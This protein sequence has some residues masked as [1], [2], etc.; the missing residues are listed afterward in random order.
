[1]P[2][3]TIEANTRIEHQ[4]GDGERDELGLLEVLLGLHGAVLG[5]RAV[6]GQLIACSRRGRHA[7]ADP[8][9]RIDRL[10]VRHGE[11]DDDVRGVAGRADEAA[12]RR[13]RHS[14]SRPRR[15]GRRPGRPSSPRWRPGTRRTGRRRRAYPSGRAR[16]CCSCRTRSPRPGGPRPPPIRMSRPASRPELS[17]LEVW[18][19]RTDE[20]S[21]MTT[22]MMATGRR[23]R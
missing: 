1:M 14:R 11:F 20:A 10:L 22:A 16:S 17:A 21:A 19:A 4:R 5:D 12:C 6:A 9:D 15:P 18:A 23:K 3:A 7:V 2:A 13:S 8:I